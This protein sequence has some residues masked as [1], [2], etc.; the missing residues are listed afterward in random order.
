[1][2]ADTPLEV[3]LQARYLMDWEKYNTI[4]QLLIDYGASDHT[5]EPEKEALI[6]QRALDWQHNGKRRET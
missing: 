2:Y 6:R 3:V 5:I 4:V 1:M